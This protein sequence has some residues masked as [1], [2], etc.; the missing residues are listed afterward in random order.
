MFGLEDQKKKDGS[1]FLFELEKKL[2]DNKEAETLIKR[3]DARVQLLKG[4]LREGEP[5]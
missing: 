4:R 1:A 5:A 3:V 2:K